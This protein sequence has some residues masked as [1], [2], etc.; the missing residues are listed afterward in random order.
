MYIYRVHKKIQQKEVV[1]MIQKLI[2]FR[3]LEILYFI[4][5][6]LLVTLLTDIFLII[7]S[8]LRY[9][10]GKLPD[11]YPVVVKQLPGLSL[12]LWK[13]VGRLKLQREVFE[14]DRSFFDIGFGDIFDDVRS[15]MHSSD[16]F[17]HPVGF[18]DNI[19]Y[20]I[21]NNLNNCS[22]VLNLLQDG[23][24]SHYFSTKKR[25][26]RKPLTLGYLTYCLFV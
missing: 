16:L 2:S 12:I 9:R 18:W 13:L 6:L 1:E 20:W 21:I 17:F 10:Q 3:F 11:V 25:W 7:G 4:K 22:T 15:N 24:F 23:V 19:F 14:I 26:L 8:L 5:G